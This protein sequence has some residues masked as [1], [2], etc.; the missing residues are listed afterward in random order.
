MDND[1]FMEVET[2]FIP[3]EDGTEMECAILDTF[4]LDGKQYMIVSAIDDDALADEDY[5]YSYTEDSDGL[6]ISSVDDDEEFARVS[7]Y[8]ERLCEEAEAET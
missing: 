2:V 5:V 8:Y 7:E 4:E 1:E 3:M 6:L